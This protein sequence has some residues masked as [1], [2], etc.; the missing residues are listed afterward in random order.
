MIR[1][2]NKENKEYIDKDQL[3]DDLLPIFN[4]L[5]PKDKG[6]IMEVIYKQEVR[7]LVDKTEVYQSNE[8]ERTFSF[9]E[10]ST[11]NDLITFFENKKRAGTFYIDINDIQKICI[12]EFPN[13][14]PVTYDIY[15]DEGN[16]AMKVTLEKMVDIVNKYCINELSKEQE[17]KD[18][19]R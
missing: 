10:N 13:D 14:I 17:G 18:I 7:N 16:L 12:L 9:T 4:R 8:N 3:I 2:L 5:S 15:S 11:K 19:E 6:D 1:P